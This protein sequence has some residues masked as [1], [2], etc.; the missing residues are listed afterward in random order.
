MTQSENRKKI[1]LIV[2]AAILVIAIAA[3]GTLAYLTASLSGDKAVVNTFVAAGGGQVVDP[4]DPVPGPNP[5]DDVT[6]DKGFYLVESKVT[7]ANAK[8]TIEP[9]AKDVLKNTYDKVVPSM[10]IPKD[11]ALTL[12]IAEGMDAY[13]FVKVIDSTGSNLSYTVDTS[14]WTEVSGV[15]LGANE[16]LYCYKNAIQTGTAEVDLNGVNILTDNRV[17]AAGTLQDQDGSTDGLQLGELK[18]E[19][20][21]CQAGGFDSAAAAFTACFGN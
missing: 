20:Y 6:L 18:F 21:V 9:D 16:K 2:L 13:V 1:L 7:Y 8:Y 17:T 15:S 14:N 11:P 3:M 5:D 4:T 19:A 12:N 10:V